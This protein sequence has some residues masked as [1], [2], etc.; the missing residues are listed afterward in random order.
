MPRDIRN[1]HQRDDHPTSPFAALMRK[2]NLVVLVLCVILASLV[3]RRLPGIDLAISG[4]FYDHGFTA[5]G[6]EALRSIRTTSITLTKFIG[7]GLVLLWLYRLLRPAAN[8]CISFAKLAFPTLVL[9]LGPLVLTNLI[10]KDQWGRPR[11]RELALFGGDAT[12]IAPWNFSDQCLRNCSFVSGETSSAIWLLTFIPFLPVVWHRSALVV[13]F[14]Y[15][16]AISLLRIAFG[17]HFASDV[18]LSILLN[19]LVVLW[20]W[21]WFFMRDGSMTPRAFANETRACGGFEHYGRG[22][23]ALEQKVLPPLRLAY[24]RVMDKVRQIS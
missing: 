1:L 18:I 3:L 24:S 20:V 22:L 9:L 14:G 4:Y 15:T 5:T 23:R 8:R 21:G 2:R 6:N 7:A 16:L 13:V 11:P 19:G 17:A 10:L 12:Y